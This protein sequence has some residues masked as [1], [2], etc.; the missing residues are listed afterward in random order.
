MGPYIAL[1]FV[2]SVE[3]NRTHGLLEYTLVGHVEPYIVLIFCKCRTIGTL[4]YINI[5]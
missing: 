4:Y 5:L 3:L 2:L 1:K